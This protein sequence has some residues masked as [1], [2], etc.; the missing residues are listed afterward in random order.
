MFYS[1]YLK[2][3]MPSERMTVLPLLGSPSHSFC[4]LPWHQL[5]LHMK[6]HTRTWYHLH[7]YCIA[8]M[9]YH[10]PKIVKYSHFWSAL[11]F[12]TQE[13]CFYQKGFSSTLHKQACSSLLEKTEIFRTSGIWTLNCIFQI[14]HNRYLIS[15]Y[16][17]KLPVC[18]NTK[19][20]KTY[21]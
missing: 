10:I 1:G 20:L 5:L 6:K 18:C 16:Q 13:Q 3:L 7:H 12:E 17:L 11:A 15:R 8:C 19:I 4:F 14:F 9:N 2:V 21:L